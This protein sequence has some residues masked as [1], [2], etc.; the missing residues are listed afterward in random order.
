MKDAECQGDGNY[1][2]ELKS[3]C[4][5]IISLTFCNKKLRDVLQRRRVSTFLLLN[6]THVIH[7]KLPCR[8]IEL[9]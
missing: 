2:T 1:K 5:V 6:I 8:N 7:N 4:A 9:N 3:I